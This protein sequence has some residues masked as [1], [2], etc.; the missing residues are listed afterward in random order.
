MIL[1]RL[2]SGVISLEPDL[3]VRVANQAAGTILGVDFADAPGRPLAEIAAGQPLLAE[4]HEVLQRHVETGETEWREQVTLRTETGRR[5]LVCAC[6]ALPG[7]AGAQGLVLVFDEVTQLLQ[8]QRQAAWGEVRAASRTRSES[9]DTD[10]ALRRAHAPQAH[11]RSL[12]RPRRSSSTARRTPS[13]SRSRRMKQ[14]VAAFSEYARRPEMHV[15]EFDL[16]ALIRQVSDLYH[17]P[18]PAGRLRP[19]RSTRRRPRSRPTRGASASS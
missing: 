6:T 4:L 9:P 15:S 10:P 19:L 2:T 16:G 3:R 8:A 18:G 12:P 5:E 14:M 7:D 1:A 11:A 17:A 13:C